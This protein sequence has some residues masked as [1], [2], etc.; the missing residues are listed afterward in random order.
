[1]MEARIGTR[2]WLAIS[3]GAPGSMIDIHHDIT[4]GRRERSTALDGMTLNEVVYPAGCRFEPHAHE[5]ANISILLAGSFFEQAGSLSSHCKTC[6]VVFKPPQTVHR[7]EVGSRGARSLI[8]GIQP[9]RFERWCNWSETLKR[10]AWVHTGPIPE[11]MLRLYREFRLGDDL[12]VASLE[13][14]LLEVLSTDFE[15]STSRMKTA[16]PLWMRQVMERLHEPREAMPRVDI[17]A[18]TVGVHPVHLARVFRRH[19]KCTIAQYIRRRR[20]E[21]A[22]H[23][24]SSSRKP[25]AEIAYETGFADQAHFS[26]SFKTHAGLSPGQFRRMTSVGTS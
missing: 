6:S 3:I 25:L 4:L 2:F 17:L 1:M 26:R 9:D 13:Q 19:H 7:N 23:A 5:Q 22:T 24:L 16:M 10:Y 12:S 20:L 15:L 18:R 21:K 8:I 14:L 11:L